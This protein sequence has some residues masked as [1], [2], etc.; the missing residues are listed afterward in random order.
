MT[1]DQLQF[2]NQIV[3]VN[4]DKTNKTLLEELKGMYR[5]SIKSGQRKAFMD[6]VKKNAIV[7]RS[8]DDKTFLSAGRSMFALADPVLKLHV[9]ANQRSKMTGNNF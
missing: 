5:Y 6:Q 4:K 2:I 9:F 8:I 7:V 3:K 1:K